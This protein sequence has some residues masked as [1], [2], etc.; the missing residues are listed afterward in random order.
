MT[1]VRTLE[2]VIEA[3]SK[4]RLLEPV[5]SAGARR[6]SFFCQGVMRAGVVPRPPVVIRCRATY[7]N[8][9]F[10]NTIA[11]SLRDTKAPIN[12]IMRPR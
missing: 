4:A 9:S 2:A 3:D 6:G 12:S 5:D 8:G 10:A 11:E 7:P 1:F